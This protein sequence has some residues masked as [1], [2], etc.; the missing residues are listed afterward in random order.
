[1]HK[2]LIIT[3]VV[4]L[5]L[6]ISNFCIAESIL[7]NIEVQ[8]DDGTLEYDILQKSIDLI[9][10]LENHEV[11]T[12]KNSNV[13][14]KIAVASLKDYQDVMYGAAIA[15]LSVEKQDNGLRKIINFDNEVVL[16]NNIENRVKE[17]IR[18]ILE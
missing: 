3:P 14:I 4:L 5:L 15:M 17:K 7:I 8:S 11:S 10:S 13:I 9:N 12:S 16:I 6:L 2:K 1:M 18:I